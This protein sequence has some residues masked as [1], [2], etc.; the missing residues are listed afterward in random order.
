[1]LD[2]HVRENL[3]EVSSMTGKSRNDY[4]SEKKL[5]PVTMRRKIV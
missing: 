1:M 5:E 2:N 4:S 3:A